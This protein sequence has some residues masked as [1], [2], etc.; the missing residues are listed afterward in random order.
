MIVIAK[1]NRVK[2]VPNGLIL[3]I[4]IDVELPSQSPGFKVGRLVPQSQSHDLGSG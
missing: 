4:I 3:T 2:N 1:K